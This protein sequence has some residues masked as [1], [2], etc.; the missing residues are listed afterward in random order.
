MATIQPAVQAGKEINIPTGIV[1][2][3]GPVKADVL[4]NLSINQKLTNFRAP[5]RQYESMIIVANLPEGMVYIARYGNE[6]VGYILFHYPSQYSRWNK[7]PRILELGAIEV[8]QDYK[9]HGIGT[10][11]LKVA[12]ENPVMEEFVVITTEFFWHWDLKNSG[13]DVMSYQR[14]LNKLFSV[15][16]F[17][18]RRT[19]DPDIL[20]HPANMLMV[21]FGS[22]VSK[23]YVNA[24]EEL[25][26][27]NSLVE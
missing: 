27:Q 5:E 9:R 22:M 13:L 8:S 11:L 20:E 6:I 26:Y 15:V 24:F 2:V 1:F 23:A 10:S 3:E 4:A 14:M 18:K 21:R 25:I 16:D 12:F 17:R 7:H 19:D